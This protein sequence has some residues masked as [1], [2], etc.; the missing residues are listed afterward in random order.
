MESR[1]VVTI[2][3]AQTTPTEGA[4]GKHL[5]CFYVCNN[6]LTHRGEGF[7][8]NF[9]EVTERRLND[10]SERLRVLETND[11]RQG[12]MIEQLCL[13]LDSLISWMKALLLAWVTGVGG[14]LIWYIQSLPR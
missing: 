14:F 2:N 7:K 10:H 11:A 1:L 4:R 6:I 13:K 5:P 12:V 8:L 9:E 3:E